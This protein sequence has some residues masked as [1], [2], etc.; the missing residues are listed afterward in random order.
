MKYY[1]KVTKCFPYINH[2]GKNSLRYYLDVKEISEG[3]YDTYIA[4]GDK[5]VLLEWLHTNWGMFADSDMDRFAQN[6]NVEVFAEPKE[7][8][9]IMHSRIMEEINNEEPMVYW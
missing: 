1:V 9:D 4:Y 2:A 7:E 3:A 5:D 8:W 6:V